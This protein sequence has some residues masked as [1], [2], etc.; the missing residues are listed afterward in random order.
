VR[1]PV[2]WTYVVLH[3]GL[4]AVF[5]LSPPL[6]FSAPSWTGMHDL[7][8]HLDP[9]RPFHVYGYAFAIA[10][11]LILGGSFTTSRAIR[12]I[13][14]AWGCLLVIFLAV[15]LT[16]TSFSQPS[17]AYTGSVAYGVLAL[18]HWRAFRY[19]RTDIG[20]NWPKG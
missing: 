14:L 6:R 15:V 2:A 8:A 7:A 20:L 17:A 12:L 4:A 3:L 10:G 9:W 11:L 1:R 18:A 5:L 13:G 16:L 19:E